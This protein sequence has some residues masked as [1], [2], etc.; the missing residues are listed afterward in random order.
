V[1]IAKP[2]NH[3]DWLPEL[4]WYSYVVILLIT[5]RVMFVTV[6]LVRTLIRRH[7]RFCARHKCFYIALHYMDIPAL[8]GHQDIKPIWLKLT[9]TVSLTAMTCGRKYM[10][11][12][13]FR[14]PFMA[15]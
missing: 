6:E 7:T 2:S 4:Q 1:Y 14:F 9:H 10:Q 15:K 11:T 12:N 5:S 3:S 13:F 8:D